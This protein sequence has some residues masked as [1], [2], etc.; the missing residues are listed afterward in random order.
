MTEQDHLLLEEFKKKVSSLMEKYEV[1][2]SEKLKLEDE[3]QTLLSQIK[4][5]EKEK[6]ELGEKYKNLKFAK[7]LHAG[8]DDNQHVKQK[9]NKLLR[10][11]DKSIALLNR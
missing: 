11:I 2:K 3:K 7:L 1:L 6:V 4:F 5:L 10:E 8:Y 9:I